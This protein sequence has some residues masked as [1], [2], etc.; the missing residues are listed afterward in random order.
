[1]SET[2]TLILLLLI[3]NGFFSISEFAIASSRKMK[4]EQLVL[5]NNLNAKK[6]LELSANPNSFITVIQISLNIIAIIAGI[7]GDHSFAPIFKEISIELGLSEKISSWIGMICS[8]LLITSSFILFSELIPKRIAFSR[9]E[10][11]ACIIITPLLMV[12]KIFKPFV[13]ILSS[14]A[15]LILNL[16][17]ISVIRDEKMTFEDVS[18][19]LNQG[20]KSG[21]LEAKEHRI[22]ENVFSLTDRSVLSAMTSKNDIVFL[23]INDNKEKINEKVLVHPHS[24]FLVCDTQLDNLLGYIDSTKLLHNLLKGNNT[25]FN[26]EKLKE[27]GLKTIVTIPDTLSL[28]EVLDKFREYREDIAAIINEFGM[29]IGL[30]TLNDVMATIMGNVLYSDTDIDNSTLIVQ[31]AKNSWLIDGKA[32]IDDVKKLFGWDEL[33]GSTSYE[34]VSGFAMYMM[35]CI[36]KKAQSFEF[37]GVVFEVV[38]VEGYRVDEVMATLKS[39]LSTEKF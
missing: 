11:I 38:D 3:L 19:I 30:I 16:L 12:L 27:Q 28:L 14:L 33:P 17:N 37:K 4:L 15:D 9:P 26:R 2:L 34:T 7:H 18:A 35:K 22:V 24:R 23:D 20:A 10:T 31:R 8:I 21:L 32:A 5:E 25:E 36:P 29:V 1:M 6:V 39:E 13:W